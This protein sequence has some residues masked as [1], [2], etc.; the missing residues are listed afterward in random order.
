MPQSLARIITHIIFSTKN[1]EPMIPAE[2]RAE[3]SAYLGGVL[4][5]FDST[6]IK[7]N[8]VADHV[9]VLCCL[10]RNYRSLEISR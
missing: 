2:Y 4:K 8:A 10:S 6:P 1:R 7:I 3:L 9:H 5:E